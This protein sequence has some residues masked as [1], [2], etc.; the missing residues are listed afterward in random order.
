MFIIGNIIMYILFN[1]M[2]KGEQQVEIT[3]YSVTSY[4]GY[5]L[6]PMLILAILGIFLSLKTGFGIFASLIL[7]GWSSYTSGALMSLALNRSEGRILIMYPLFL[8][9]LSFALI[10]IF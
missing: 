4:L 2:V 6:L 7:A 3:L 9:Y 10:I 5:S 1:F 8:F